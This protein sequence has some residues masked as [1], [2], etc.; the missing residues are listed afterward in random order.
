LNGFRNFA[1]PEAGAPTWVWNG[2]WNDAV[3]RFDKRAKEWHLRGAKGFPPA[4]LPEIPA[5]PQGGP[6]GPPPFFT[7]SQRCVMPG[8]LPVSR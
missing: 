5:K 4:Q 7:V 8:G 6:G 3:P 1:V 2:L